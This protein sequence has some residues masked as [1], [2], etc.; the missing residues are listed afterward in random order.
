MI[1]TTTEYLVTFHAAAERL[2]VT[3]TELIALVVQRS[4]KRPVKVA[5]E[6]KFFGSDVNGFLGRL[7]RTR[8]R[9]LSLNVF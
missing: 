3:T 2:A 1:D 6:L 5:G 8:Q 4:I 7:Y 9:S